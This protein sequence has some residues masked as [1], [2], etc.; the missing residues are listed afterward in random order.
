[1]MLLDLR[2]ERRS[3]EQRLAKDFWP[4]QYAPAYDF[5]SYRFKK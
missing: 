5:Y 4:L 2:S 3:V 1:M